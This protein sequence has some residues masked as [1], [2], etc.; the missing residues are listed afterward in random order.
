MGL[1]ITAHLHAWVKCRN[2]SHSFADINSTALHKMLGFSFS[3]PAI[4]KI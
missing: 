4:T 3:P 1:M 2:V